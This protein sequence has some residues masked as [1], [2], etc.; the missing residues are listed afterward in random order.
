VPRTGSTC[1]RPTTSGYGNSSSSTGPPSTATRCATSRVRNRYSYAID[2][3]L[4]YIDPFGE[5]WFSTDEGWVFFD[6]VDTIEEIV[7]KQD[8]TTTTRQ[9]QGLSSLV[10]FDGSTLVLHRSDGSTLDF[11][12]T[13]GVLDERDKTCGSSAPSSQE[14]M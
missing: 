7:V 12:A 11:D 10:T 2:N 4:K 8:G 5:L 1:T 3:P 14:S 9:V 6:D 13:S